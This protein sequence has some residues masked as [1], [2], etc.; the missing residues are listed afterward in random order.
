MAKGLFTSIVA[1][2]QT[3]MLKIF[4]SMFCAFSCRTKRI[5]VNKPVF[6]I[7]AQNIGWEVQ[8]T[9]R[10][11]TNFPSHQT[12]RTSQLNSCVVHLRGWKILSLCYSHKVRQESFSTLQE[13]VGLNSHRFMSKW[14]QFLDSVK[15]MDS[16][17]HM[18]EW[19]QERKAVSFQH[20]NCHCLAVV[21]RVRD[22]MYCTQLLLSLP[23]SIV[24]YAGSCSCIVLLASVDLPNLQLKYRRPS[25]PLK[26][27]HASCDYCNYRYR[28]YMWKASFPFLLLVHTLF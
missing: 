18:C 11:C 3:R 23:G 2:T 6:C 9:T 8:Q 5:S 13:H 22:N 16:L 26:G 20:K 21:P 14:R 17:W 24:S 28:L 4:P 12:N 27:L 1:T 15:N 25:N 7:C 19:H 10:N